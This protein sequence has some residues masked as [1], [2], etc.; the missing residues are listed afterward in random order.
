ML[1]GM[2]AALLWRIKARP[3]VKHGPQAPKLLPL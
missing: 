2:L 3:Q 1:L